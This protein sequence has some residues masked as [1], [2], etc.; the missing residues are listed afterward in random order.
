MGK[1]GSRWHHGYIPA[2]AAAVALK[3]HK[4]PGGKLPEIYKGDLST[5]DARRSRPVSSAEFQSI[6]Q[7]GKAKLAARSAKSSA[8][9]GLDKNWKA[10]TERAYAESRKDWGGVT[11]DSHTGL[12]VPHDADAYA[13]TVRNPGSSH[14]SI[15]ANSPKPVFLAAMKKARLQHS[16]ELSREGAH[17]GVFHDNDKGSID[18]DPVMVVHNLRDVEDI[19]AY[20][21]AV[22][23]AYHFKSGDGF[24][25]PH[26]VGKVRKEKAA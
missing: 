2:N 12:D 1:D 10:I 5:P 13:L 4:S 11:V 15:P 8:P 6:A 26:V 24:W 3:D 9:E 22:G 18:I 21:H 16:E 17:L 19:G 14:I 20:T 7:R 23:G 25:P